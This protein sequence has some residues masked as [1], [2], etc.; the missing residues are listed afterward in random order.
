MQLG[1]KFISSH[2][3]IFLVIRLFWRVAKPYNDTN[4]TT[5]LDKDF[6]TRLTLNLFQNP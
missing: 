1:V 6:D 4:L 2:V 5:A 3:D